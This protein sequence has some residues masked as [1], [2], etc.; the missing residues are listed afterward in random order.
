MRA[1]GGRAAIRCTSKRSTSPLMPWLKVA[2]D[3]VTP[4]HK[5]LG[6]SE[7]IGHNRGMVKRPRRP[8]DPNQLGKLI[9]DLSVG[10]ASEAEPIPD[11]HAVAFARQGGLKGGQAR[12]QVLTPERRREI[13][14]IA[15]KRRW[16]S[17]SDNGTG[18]GG[19]RDR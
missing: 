18:S 12:A 10:E 7:S 4:G 14:R 6:I 11:S 17:K 1:L 19:E 16:G 13:A 3:F 15:A 8:R 5:R 2:P 9:V